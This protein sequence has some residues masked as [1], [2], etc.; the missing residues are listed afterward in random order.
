MSVESQI[1][2]LP[3]ERMTVRDL[4][5]GLLA[6]SGN[7]AAMALAEGVGRLRARVRA[8]DEPPRAR[9]GPD[10]HPLP[11]PDRPR[12]GGRVLER[13]RPR[14]AR[15]RTCAPSRSS[16]A[17]SNKAERAAHVRRPSAPLRQPQR[18]RR[19]ASSGSTASRP[20]T[21]AAPAT[22]WSA[23]AART[24]SRSSPPSSGTPSEAARDAD[25]LRAAELRPPRRSS[26]SPPRPRA[27]ASAS[28]CR[29]TFRHGAELELV[30]GPNGQRT[31]VPRGERDRVR[32]RA[33]HRT[34]AR[35]KGPIAAGQQLGSRGVLQDDRRIAT[36]PLV[37]ERGGPGG[38]HSAA[39]QVLVQQ[40]DRGRARLC[41]PGRYGA[42]WHGGGA[43]DP[44]DRARRAREEA[45]TA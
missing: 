5:R 39:H 20:A 36:V 23:P 2:L 10:Q 1:G 7:D 28:A 45:R 4:L 16:A 22:C 6:E 35:S 43:G 12:R 44:A 3:G 17:P 21:R 27:A 9:A 38:R 33:A 40:A 15:H 34:R 30:V 42:S 14:D 37:V 19:R 8:A 26:A 32:G 29:S 13:S 11:Q 25:T 41:R 31:V 24:G 18:P